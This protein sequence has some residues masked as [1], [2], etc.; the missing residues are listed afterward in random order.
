MGDGPPSHT[1]SVR[2]AR[3]TGWCC[4]RAPVPGEAARQAGRPGRGLAGDRA[5]AVPRRVRCAGQA[6]GG[7]AADARAARP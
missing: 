1:T 2:K 7:S 3:R 5:N 6:A 4:G